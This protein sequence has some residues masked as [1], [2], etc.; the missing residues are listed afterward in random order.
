[1]DSIQSPFDRTEQLREVTIG[2]ASHIA[3][4]WA[5]SLKNLLQDSNY[6]LMSGNALLPNKRQTPENRS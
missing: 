3:Q 1:M 5:Q 6:I 2:R 4:N